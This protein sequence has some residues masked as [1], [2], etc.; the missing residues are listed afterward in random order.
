MHT[1]TRRNL[2]QLGGAGLMGLTLPRLLHAEA[3]NRQATRR[4]ARAPSPGALGPV[5]GITEARGEVEELAHG[6]RRALCLGRDHPFAIEPDE[7]RDLVSHIRDVEEALGDGVK[8]G[9]STE[10]A[11]VMYVKARRSVV[12]FVAI[13]AGAR[14][15]RDMLTVKRP[16]FG[17]KPRFIDALVG[18][19]AARDIEEDEVITWDMI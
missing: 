5:R 16:G 4:T 6:H 12:S 9:P 15:T 2:L 17:I 1:I 7:L 11:S 19:V 14:L 3:E 8:S 10:E 18:R 13:P